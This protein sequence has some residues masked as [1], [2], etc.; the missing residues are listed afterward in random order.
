M[1]VFY[2][3]ATVRSGAC[4]ADDRTAGV[5]DRPGAPLRPDHR[6]PMTTSSTPPA[7]DTAPPGK[8]LQVPLMRG[9]VVAQFV[10]GV[11]SAVV[12]LAIAF[13]SYEDSKSVLHT[14]LVSAAYSLPTAIFGMYAGR[15]AGRVSRRHLLL[16]INVLKTGLYLGM[17]VLAALDLLNVPGLMVMSLVAGTLSAF[18]SPAWMEFE[19]DVVPHDRLEEA[20]A[21]LGA[22][23]SSA[24]VIGAA[25]GAVLLATVGPWSMF[26]VNSAS[27]LGWI[28][29]LLRA[30]P[31]EEIVTSPHRTTLR[32]AIHYIGGD[33]VMKRVFIRVALLSLFVGPIV[34]LLPAV[35]DDLSGSKAS[36][37]VLT[38]AFAIG[39][40][41]VAQLIGRLK[42]HHENAAILNLTFVMSGVV[43]IA[44]G[45]SGDAMHG[46]PLWV[47]VLA[48]LVPLGLLLSLAQSVLSGGVERNVTPEMEGAVFALYAIVYTVLAPLGGFALAQFADHRDVWDALTLSGVVIV[49]AGVLSLLFWRTTAEST[50]QPTTDATPR[51]SRVALD[52]L[53]RGHLLDL[54]RHPRGRSDPP[55]S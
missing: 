49:V 37:G 48:A 26:V 35:A 9:L 34:Q 32:E 53:L 13:L 42:A 21:L 16:V 1:P 20:N 2:R 40:I 11:G 44:F 8:L 31:T 4:N 47:V 18:N 7:A 51:Q 55:A 14:V 22:A 3:P 33:P 50:P 25:L 41:L 5:Y 46:R 54:H 45:R 52:G 12:T 19:R 39:A 36:L 38:G 28:L 43:L 29:V 27:F 6:P 17:A 10:S 24:A 30:H 15:L 23:S